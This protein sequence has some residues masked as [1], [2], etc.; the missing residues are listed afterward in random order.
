[1]LEKMREMDEAK[2]QKER[3]LNEIERN[4]LMKEMRKN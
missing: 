3:H 1:M 2:A 4:R